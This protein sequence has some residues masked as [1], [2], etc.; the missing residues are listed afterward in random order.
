M[1][2]GRR[3]N[4][5]SSDSSSSSWDDYKRDQKINTKFSTDSDDSED[6]NYTSSNSEEGPRLKSIK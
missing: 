6:M 4:P 1:Y 5:D 2:K 3:N